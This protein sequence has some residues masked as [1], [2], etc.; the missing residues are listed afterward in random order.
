MFITV[1]LQSVI[2]F[3]AESVVFKATTFSVTLEFEA[4]DSS[5]FSGIK[6]G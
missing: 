3:S 5:Y 6:A 4:N 1:D 2:D